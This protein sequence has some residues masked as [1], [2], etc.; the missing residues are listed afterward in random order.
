MPKRLSVVL[1]KKGELERETGLEPATFSLEGWRSR[2]RPLPEAE[3]V[4]PGSRRYQV[5]VS[6]TVAGSQG[7]ETPIV[8][9]DSW[10]STCDPSP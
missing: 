6:A 8:F 4:R 7:Y 5:M 2:R 1:C 3:G 10:Q 9:R